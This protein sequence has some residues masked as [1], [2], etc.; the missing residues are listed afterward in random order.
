VLAKTNEDEIGPEV[1]V[2]ELDDSRYGMGGR[3]QLGVQKPCWIKVT[4]LEMGNSFG[5]ELLDLYGSNWGTTNFEPCAS[6]LERYGAISHTSPERFRKPK[7]QLRST[8]FTHNIVEAAALN[9]QRK[10]DV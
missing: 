1:I 9:E 5:S 3:E 8:H 4:S 10:T 2:E 7:I 6:S